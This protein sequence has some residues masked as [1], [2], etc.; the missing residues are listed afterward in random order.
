MPSI[1][2]G[3]TASPE[4]RAQAI[5]AADEIGVP[6]AEYMRQAMIHLVKKRTNPFNE[7]S[8]IKIGRPPKACA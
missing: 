4:L 2:V 5:A 6:F 1:K 8:A 7:R 3:F